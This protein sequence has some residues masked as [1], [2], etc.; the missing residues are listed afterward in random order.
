M[1]FGELYLRNRVNCVHQTIWASWSYELHH[2]VFIA[3]I[4]SL[5]TSSYH[6]IESWLNGSSETRFDK[7]HSNWGFFCF[8]RWEH[9][10]EASARVQIC[11][12]LVVGRRLNSFANSLKF[13][14]SFLILQ[15]RISIIFLVS[16]P[17]W[18]T[19]I[20]FI[21]STKQWVLPKLFCTP[22]WSWSVVRAA[23]V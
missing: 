1:V 23:E 15:C 21:H 20:E 16:W 11:R 9:L 7:C 2:E 8:S 6:E 3:L 12:S 22:R 10:L 13:K 5:W 19:F 17:C 18:I 14:G 4:Q